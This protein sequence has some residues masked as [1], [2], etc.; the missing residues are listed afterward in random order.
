[1]KTSICGLCL[2][3]NTK[4]FGTSTTI[5]ELSNANSQVQTLEK[6]GSVSVRKVLGKYSRKVS[7]YVKV[8]V[9]GEELKSSSDHEFKTDKGWFSAGSLRKGMML[10]SMALNSFVP[11][12]SVANIHEPLTVEGLALGNVEGYGV[13]KIG[14]VV[15]PSNGWCVKG[16]ERIGLKK[17]QDWVTNQAEFKFVGLTGENAIKAYIQELETILSGKNVTGI[18][19]NEMGLIVKTDGSTFGI[20]KDINGNLAND[21]S[22]NKIFEYKATYKDAEY[23]HSVNGLCMSYEGV[24]GALFDVGSTGKK[25][26]VKIKMKGKRSGYGADFHEAN[27]E[28]GFATRGDKNGLIDAPTGPNGEAYTWHHL[29]DFNPATGE[30]TMQLVKRDFHGVMTGKNRKHTGSVKQWEFYNNKKYD[31]PITD[32]ECDN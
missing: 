26:I 16:L 17:F 14:F 31:K 27:I 4:V 29:D 20:H 3:E 30:C 8:F 1:M 25:N 22:N 11:I 21:I 6:D 12:E 32:L 9:A 18:I 23:P 15:A 10:F 24:A 2:A 13:G 7:D 19:E 28:A 5:S